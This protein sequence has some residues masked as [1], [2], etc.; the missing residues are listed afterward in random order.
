MEKIPYASLGSLGEEFHFAFE[1]GLSEVRAKFGLFYPFHIGGKF[2]KAKAGTFIDRC[3]AD[4]QIVLGH[5]QS[6]DRADV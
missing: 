2:R 4:T 6:G 1:A 3:P 5:F